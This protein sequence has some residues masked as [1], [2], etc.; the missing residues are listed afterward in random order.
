MSEYPYEDKIHSGDRVN[1]KIVY[2]AR[3]KNG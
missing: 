2:S 3:D 1:Y